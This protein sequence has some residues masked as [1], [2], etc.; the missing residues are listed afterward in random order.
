MPS[1]TKQ[2]ATAVV[3]QI[4]DCLDAEDAEGAYRI[5]TE[6][7]PEMLDRVSSGLMHIAVAVEAAKSMK[8]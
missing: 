4:L 7:T 6:Q 5:A 8:V 1:V 3:R 2:E